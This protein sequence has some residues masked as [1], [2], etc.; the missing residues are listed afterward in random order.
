MFLSEFKF[1]RR[2]WSTVEFQIFTDRALNDFRPRTCV[3]FPLMVVYVM[4]CVDTVVLYEDILVD[5]D[6][7]HS[8]VC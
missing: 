7:Y 4:V 3:V 2:G 1:F 5:V 6:G 8:D